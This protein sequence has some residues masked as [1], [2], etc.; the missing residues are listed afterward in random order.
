QHVPV[1]VVGSELLNP[2]GEFASEVIDPDADVVAACERVARAPLHDHTDAA[3]RAVRAVLDRRGG[4][5]T[6][7]IAGRRRPRRLLVEVCGADGC[8]E[9]TKRVASVRIVAAVRAIDR[10]ARGIDVAFATRD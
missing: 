6:P 2:F 1:V 8:D 10:T 4:A 9:E 5:T 7:M 3:A